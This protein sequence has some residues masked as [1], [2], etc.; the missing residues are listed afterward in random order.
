MLKNVKKFVISKKEAFKVGYDPS[1]MSDAIWS[2]IKGCATC[3]TE[4]ILAVVVTV[5]YRAV[6]DGENKILMKEATKKWENLFKE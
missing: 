1:V 5:V 4:I 2:T 6:A 3:T